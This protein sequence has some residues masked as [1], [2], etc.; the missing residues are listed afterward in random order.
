MQFGL[1]CQKTQFMADHLGMQEAVLQAQS[2]LA[3]WSAFR[4]EAGI[5]AFALEA[6]PI[7]GCAC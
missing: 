7:A 5:L 4:P 6:G 2:Q 3:M 1:K